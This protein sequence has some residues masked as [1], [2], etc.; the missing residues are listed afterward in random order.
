[1]SMCPRCDTNHGGYPDGSLGAELRCL[2]HQAEQAD[3][4]DV[5]DKLDELERRRARQTVAAILN[6]Y[7]DES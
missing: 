5:L 4:Q 6:V 3:A 1:M 2:R 7:R